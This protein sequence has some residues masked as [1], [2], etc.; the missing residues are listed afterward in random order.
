MFFM[1]TQSILKS[2][3]RASLK[4]LERLC[5]NTRKSTQQMSF[6]SLS[7]SL[8]LSRWGDVHWLLLSLNSSGMVTFL[9][10]ESGRGDSLTG[11]E[12]DI[13]GYRFVL[14]QG[15]NLGLW[16]QDI[17]FFEKAMVFV[18]YS[19]VVLGRVSDFF[20]LYPTSS[21]SGLLTDVMPKPPRIIFPFS[22]HEV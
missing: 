15:L 19:S 2:D 22:I 7:G 1:F 3:L 10:A 8:S 20:F 6:H 12:E 21:S 16:V 9:M 5:L 17:F 4:W 11:L 13:V 14:G 18:W